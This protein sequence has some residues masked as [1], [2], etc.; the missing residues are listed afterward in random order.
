MMISD[1]LESELAQEGHLGKK[2][3]TYNLGVLF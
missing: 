2:S 1:G 3:T